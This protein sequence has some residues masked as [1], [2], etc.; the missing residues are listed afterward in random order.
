MK[1]TA[2]ISMYPLS[3]DYIPRITKFIERLK[4]ESG[5]K[6]EVNSTSTRLSGNSELVYQVLKQEM[7]ESRVESGQA[8]FVTKFL[9]GDL[10]S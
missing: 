8:I 1:I 4:A 2:E 6:I 7:E 9:L 3:D 5:I 10:L